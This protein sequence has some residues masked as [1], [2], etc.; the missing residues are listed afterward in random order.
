MA[1]FILH[2]IHFAIPGDKSQDLDYLHVFFGR[3]KKNLNHL[4]IIMF[5]MN[6]LVNSSQ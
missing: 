6:S 1:F 5:V 2:K 4:A 3:G